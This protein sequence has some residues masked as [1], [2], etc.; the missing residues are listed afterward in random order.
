MRESTSSSAPPASAL[1]GD[2]GR[3]QHDVESKAGVPVQSV[4]DVDRQ[5]VGGL[6]LTPDDA[7]AV[8]AGR[9]RR[10]AMRDRTSRSEAGAAEPPRCCGAPFYLLNSPVSVPRARV[11]SST[12]WCT[13]SASGSAGRSIGRDSANKLKT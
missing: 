6:G 5:A 11:M 3:G 1:P 4:D 8:E 12:A 9:Q 7:A 10:H 2:A 13:S